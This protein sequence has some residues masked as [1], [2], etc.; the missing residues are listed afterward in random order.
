MGSP[1]PSEAPEAAAPE[2]AA[3]SETADS[4]AGAAPDAAAPEPGDASTKAGPLTKLVQKLGTPPNCANPF[5]AALNRIYGLQSSSWTWDAADLLSLP[6]P[7]FVRV[8]V[9]HAQLTAD[10]AAARRAG[11]V[12]AAAVF[13]EAATALAIEERYQILLTFL[14]AMACLHAPEPEVSAAAAA[15]DD[16]NAAVVHL[17]NEALAVL[18]PILTDNTEALDVE[19]LQAL[20]ALARALRLGTLPAALQDVV[21]RRSL[22][23]TAMGAAMRAGGAP[24]GPLGGGHRARARLA[25]AAGAARCLA[26]AGVCAAA[27]QAWLQDAVKQAQKRLA[28]PVDPAPEPAAAASKLRADV[29]P[30]QMAGDRPAPAGAPAPGGGAGAN[31]RVNAPSFCPRAD[32]VP[33]R[34]VA[35]APPFRPIRPVAVARRLGAGPAAREPAPSPAPSAATSDTCSLG[36]AGSEQEHTDPLVFLRGVA[37]L[38]TA[39]DIHAALA[40]LRLKPW[41]IHRILNAEGGLRSNVI[42]EFASMRDALACARY[43]RRFLPRELPSGV[44]LPHSSSFTTQLVTR[45]V[46]D[47]TPTRAEWPTGP[48]TGQ[49]ALPIYNVPQ[50]IMPKRGLSDEGGYDPAEAGEPRAAAPPNPVVNAPVIAA[51]RAAAPPDPVVNVPV[52]AAPPVPVITELTGADAALLNANAHLVRVTNLPRPAVEADVRSFIGSIRGRVLM[53]GVFLLLDKPGGKPVGTAWVDFVGERN[54]K[55]AVEQRNGR[56]MRVPG[57]R[58]NFCQPVVLVHSSWAKVLPRVALRTDARMPPGWR[59][60]TPPLPPVIIDPA[61]LPGRRV[62]N[63]TALDDCKDSFDALPNACGDLAERAGSMDPAAEHTAPGPPEGPPALAQAPLLVP[64]AHG[65]SPLAVLAG[66]LQLPVPGPGAAP[67]PAR[68]A[69]MPTPVLLAHI[70]AAMPRPTARAPTAFVTPLPPPVQPKA[71]YAP[72]LGGELGAKPAETLNP[73]AG[74]AGATHG[75]ISAVSAAPRAGGGVP[76]GGASP[77]P[78]G[79]ATAVAPRLRRGLKDVNEEELCCPIT[80]DIMRDPVMCADGFSYERSAIEDWLSR[81]KTSPMTNEELQHMRLTPNISLRNLISRTAWCRL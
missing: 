32:V 79:T 30:F 40:G 59:P 2:V 29:A 37:P 7:W 62:D 48:A 31:L 35:D 58:V 18:C 22:P 28:A 67:A 23:M 6:G 70:H 10:D 73:G 26:G 45:A 36:A 21:Q 39:L 14:A 57:A 50:L 24:L 75:L 53:R 43:E 42:I 54:A 33:F 64:G 52:V 19:A 3:R 11:A 15:L 71:R 5:V 27:E 4:A 44:V 17:W 55:L 34:P 80:Q 78:G 76:G 56:K 41:G 1:P 49:D 61:E 16:T 60:S 12:A 20:G 13:E 8:A 46:L 47:A 68:L 65:V 77:K 81:H 72:A 69:A 66:V 9:L 38:A 74:D 25:A 63:I 51:P